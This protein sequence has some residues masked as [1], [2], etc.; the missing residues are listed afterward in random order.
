MSSHH[1]PITARWLSR[2]DQRV[3]ITNLC[4]GAFFLLILA[5]PW[6][7]DGIGNWVIFAIGS[8]YVLLASYFL[9][10][11]YGR[12]TLTVR[13]EAST[14]AAPWLVAV[15]IWTWLG[16]MVDDFSISWAH[17][18]FGLVIGTGCYLAWQLVSL[19]L[20]TIV[21]SQDH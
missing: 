12:P 21:S 5:V 14:W 6:R 16:A 17:L 8:A 10:A 4:S 13:Q 20:R 18:L 3:L 15:A 19:F 2:L 11:M 7:D 9:A 1:V